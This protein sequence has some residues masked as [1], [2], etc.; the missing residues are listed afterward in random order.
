M[1]VRGRLMPRVLGFR[2]PSSG[3]RMCVRLGHS[4]PWRAALRALSPRKGVWP[5]SPGWADDTLFA[6]PDWGE[7][8]D[9]SRLDEWMRD[10]CECMGVRR[11]GTH[12]THGM[13][14][15]G[16]GSIWGWALGLEAYISRSLPR[17]RSGSE[18][19][20]CYL[21]LLFSAYEI[22]SVSIVHQEAKLE[23]HTPALLPTYP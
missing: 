7:R 16:W 10:E 21:A 9:I 19:D 22:I 1:L 14:H 18:S 20:F 6:L 11:L 2:C 15:A 5:L 13:A 12:G 23:A 17:G 8:R 4:V 3:A